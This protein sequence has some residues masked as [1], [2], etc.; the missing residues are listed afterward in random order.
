MEGPVA[1][2][3]GG[4]GALGRS[5]VPM[6]ARRDFRM[7]ITYLIPEEA[8]QIEDEI[9]LDSDRLML[10]RV[11]CT[12]TEATEAFMKD[13][14]DTFG[15]IN[16][17]AA[18]VGGWA[19]GRDVAETDDVRF[20][21]MIDL[22]LRSTFNAVRGAIPHMRESSWGRLIAVGSRAAVD[23]PAGQ[24]AFNVAKAGVLALM[25]TTA[26][27]LDDTA[28]TSN[29]VLP[30][31]IDTPATRKAFAFADYVRWPKPDEI[32]AV[33]DYLASPASTVINGGAIPVYGK[34]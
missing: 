10:R 20:D 5:L 1:V 21:R 27:E 13:A 34:S 12:D 31:V 15:P 14:Y 16:V 29:V 32:A 33:I 23:T 25:K 3:T 6:L 8:A 7:A 4:T 9:D 26:Q 30:A 22:N 17:M 28:I 18:L 2:I 19:G 11:D 24:G